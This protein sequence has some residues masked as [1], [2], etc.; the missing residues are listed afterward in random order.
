MRM[1]GR[2]SSASSVREGKI[3]MNNRG[4]RVK[5][6]F[7]ERLYGS[8]V[9]QLGPFWP[10][11]LPLKVALRSHATEIE[12]NP[13]KIGNCR[14]SYLAGEGRQ[15]RGRLAFNYTSILSA[16]GSYIARSSVGCFTSGCVWYLERAER[17]FRRRRR[18]RVSS[19]IYGGQSQISGVRRAPF[20]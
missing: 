13:N 19:D 12:S 10:P 11:E 9:N 17:R 20:D 15:I 2:K 8:L 3:L 6:V 1:Y 14:S 18:H 16:I 5:G 7:L 4:K